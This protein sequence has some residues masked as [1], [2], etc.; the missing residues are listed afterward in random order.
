LDDPL[1]GWETKGN[2]TQVSRWTIAEIER[3]T[4]RGLI[5]LRKDERIV[6]FLPIHLVSGTCDVLTPLVPVSHN[7]QKLVQILCGPS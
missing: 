6:E 3:L 4:G 5:L 2:Y 7:M 1:T